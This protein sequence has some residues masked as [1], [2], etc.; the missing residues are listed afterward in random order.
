MLLALE[1]GQVAAEA[2]GKHLPEL[3]TGVGFERLAGAYE[4]EYLRRFQTRLRFSSL[5]RRAAFVP[6]LDEAGILLLGNSARLRRKL[7]RATRHS[8]GSEAALSNR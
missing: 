6:R 7:A 8:N 5:L 2:L 4:T 3:R 1:S